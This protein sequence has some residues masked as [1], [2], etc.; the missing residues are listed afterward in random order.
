MKVKLAGKE[1]PIWW[2]LNQSIEYCDLR[3]ITVTQYHEE[4]TK[5]ADSTG[6]EMR[7]LIWSALK[8]GARKEGQEFS[9]TNYDVGD[10][11]DQVQ[12][13]EMEEVIKSLT[14]SLTSRKPEVKKKVSK[15]APVEL[16]K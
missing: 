13:G 15:A 12:E 7:D 8:D 10:L 5:L 1:Y 11:L 4:L 2:G 9:L 3:G 14:E 6:A 16:S